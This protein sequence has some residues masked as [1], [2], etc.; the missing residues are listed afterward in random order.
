MQLE[1]WSELSFT[2]DILQDNPPNTAT[3]LCQCS[4]DSI[5]SMYFLLC[6]DTK[7]SVC[8]VSGNCCSTLYA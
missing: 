1:A 3:H 5:Y 7:S 4:L 2:E 6:A 8:K